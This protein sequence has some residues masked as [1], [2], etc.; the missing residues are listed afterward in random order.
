MAQKKLTIKFYPDGAV[1]RMHNKRVSFKIEKGNTTIG[2]QFADADANKPA[3][4]HI[5]HKG[6]VRHT[7]LKISDEGMDA[8]VYAYL[9][10]KMLKFENKI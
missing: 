9:K 7:I 8:L 2:F 5:C 4:Y 6:K 10:R 1:I 3:C